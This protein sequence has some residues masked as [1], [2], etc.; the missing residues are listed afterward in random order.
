MKLEWDQ[1]FYR[2]R[3]RTTLGYAFGLHVLQCSHQ[4][5]FEVGCV[6]FQSY[7]TQMRVIDRWLNFRCCWL[8]W[9]LLMDSYRLRLKT[10]WSLIQI[11]Y[12]IDN[13]EYLIC[14]HIR[15]RSTWI[16]IPWFF[17]RLA[18]VDLEV[19]GFLR[20]QRTAEITKNTKTSAP[21]TANNIA[22]IG[23]TLNLECPFPPRPPPSLVNAF[24]PDSSK[25]S[26]TFVVRA[27][28]RRGTLRPKRKKKR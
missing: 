11:V 21:P 6:L 10:Q 23:V 18:A 3:K 2:L 9:L 8:I 5:L 7:L 27:F 26:G 24:P 28:S 19:E 20:I 16:Q 17:L 12:S 14:E 4:Y 22:R 1:D 15:K 25:W 13:I